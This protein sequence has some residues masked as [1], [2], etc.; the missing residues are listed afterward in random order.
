MSDNNPR[1]IT[2]NMDHGGQGDLLTEMTRAYLHTGTP[3]AFLTRALEGVVK[4]RQ[5]TQA[6][7]SSEDNRLLSEIETQL[8]TLREGLRKMEDTVYGSLT[9]DHHIG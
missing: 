8:R 4:Y 1:N 2:L 7:A 6:S 9:P 3:S 5:E